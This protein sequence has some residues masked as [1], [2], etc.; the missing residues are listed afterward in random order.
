MSG[1]GPPLL[2]LEDVHT[3]YGTIEAIK[4]ISLKVQE[5]EVVTL[6]G[7]NGAGKSTTLKSIAALL[8]LAGGVIKLAGKSTE[9]MSTEDLVAAGVSLAPEGRA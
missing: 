9:G 6:I 2:E 5:G 4:G 1:N 7:A 3:Y 8:K